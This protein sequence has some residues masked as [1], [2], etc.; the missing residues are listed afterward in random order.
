MAILFNRIITPL[1]TS[2]PTFLLSQLPSFSWGKEDRFLPKMHHDMA[3]A[4]P[5]LPWCQSLAAGGVRFRSLLSNE[6]PLLWLSGCVVIESPSWANRSEINDTKTQHRTGQSLNLLQHPTF[7][8]SFH[9]AGQIAFR[10]S[11]RLCPVPFFHL[12][13][14]FLTVFGGLKYLQVIGSAGRWSR[15]CNE[16]TLGY[17]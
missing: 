14:C 2:C 11:R 4:W 10:Y 7:Y 3:S 5:R 9:C 17:T 16:L 12:R 13:L 15:V 8:Y 1:F 6:N